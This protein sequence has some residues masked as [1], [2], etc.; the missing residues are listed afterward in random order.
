MALKPYDQLVSAQLCFLIFPNFSFIFRLK[1]IDL[2]MNDSFR[3]ELQ[4]AR[5]SI[6]RHGAQPPFQLPWEKGIWKRIFNPH[7]SPLSAISRSLP[8][9][10][11]FSTSSSSSPPL[12]SLPNFNS[13]S[14]QLLSFDTSYGEK[15]TIHDIAFPTTAVP[16]AEFWSK[17]FNRSDLQ[18]GRVDAISRF[19][20]ML[21]SSTGSSMFLSSSDPWDLHASFSAAVSMKAT[22]TLIKRSLDLLRF[23]TW[24][25][26]HDKQFLPF[27]EC[28]LWQFLRELRMTAKPSGPQSILQAINFAIHVLGCHTA[29]PTLASVRIKGLCS[30][31]KAM[32]LTIKHAP[33]LQVGQI[34]HLENLMLFL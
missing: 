18:Q 24:C 20:S 29:G 1:F 3:I 22:S 32:A 27:S 7:S 16:S 26:F 21:A 8:L 6:E 10:S 4:S 17:F 30:G 13:N 9:P 12:D 31:H 25:D 14:S 33:P 23:K 5:A 28:T 19:I 15:S 11:S 2:I 34:T